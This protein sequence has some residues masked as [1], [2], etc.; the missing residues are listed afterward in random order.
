[1][2]L[3]ACHALHPSL[4]TR[5]GQALVE[6]AILGAMILLVLGVLVDYGLRADYTQHAMMSTFRRV[7][8]DAA[9]QTRDGVPISTS[10]L[11][12]ADRRIPDPINPF[13]LGPSATITASAGGVTQN[14]QM[15]KTPD[16]TADMPHFY[17]LIGGAEV[18]CG[19]I[20]CLT[21]GIRCAPAYAPAGF[22]ANLPRYQVVYGASN[23]CVV[24]G[25]TCPVGECQIGQ[26]FIQDPCMGE[27]VDVDMCRRL[28]RLMT[29]SAA[30]EYECNL[31]GR[32]YCAAVCGYEMDRPWYTTATEEQWAALEHLGIQPGST[33]RSVLKGPVAGDAF[34]QKLESAERIGTT[35]A[36][37][38][39]ETTT[40][41]FVYRN[42]SAGADPAPAKTVTS[43][44]AVDGA[45]YWE[46][47]W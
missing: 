24:D 33:R 29:N 28:A 7:L 5:A 41:R 12:F 30:C 2:S 6:L 38:S 46:T 43:T 3:V 47:A 9:A 16:T 44:S 32:D 21:S 10:R 22:V 35:T 15:H 18:N 4:R 23:V 42:R 8:K 27:I 45:V 13:S 39:E 11:S 36:F 17:A 34:I 26:L 37:E 25:K 14:Y 31:E 20:G 40:R 1:M 19:G